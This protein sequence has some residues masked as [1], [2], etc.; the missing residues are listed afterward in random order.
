[1]K[2]FEEVANQPATWFIDPPYIDKG[3]Y[4]KYGSKDINYNFLKNWCQERQDQVI[5]CEDI[6]ASWLPFESL[7]TSRGAKYQHHEAIWLS[8]NLRGDA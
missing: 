7:I 2:S 4:Y 3:K 1:M 8:D 6:N 5:V